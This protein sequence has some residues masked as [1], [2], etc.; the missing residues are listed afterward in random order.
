MDSQN[1]D[2][3]IKTKS[4]PVQR[5]VVN[6]TESMNRTKAHEEKKEVGCPPDKTTENTKTE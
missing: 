4:R 6:L 3:L 2:S 1:Q 5:L